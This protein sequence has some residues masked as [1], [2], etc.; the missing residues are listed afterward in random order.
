MPFSHNASEMFE[1]C[2]RAWSGCFLSWIWHIETFCILCRNDNVTRKDT[3]RI[4]Y[5][6]TETFLWRIKGLYHFKKHYWC[7][8][9][10]LQEGHC[11]CPKRVCLTRSLLTLVH[12]VDFEIWA[13]LWTPASP[14][15][16]NL[17]FFDMKFAFSPP[18]VVLLMATKH[19]NFE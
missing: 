4:G 18:I 1:R 11:T 16:A 5:V 8:W 9:C 2:D 6:E 14:V 7:R 13:I 12:D 19:N 10:M 3:R 17:R 15:C